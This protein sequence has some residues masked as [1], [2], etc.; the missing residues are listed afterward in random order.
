MGGGVRL[1]VCGGFSVSVGTII[2]PVHVF[3]ASSCSDRVCIRRLQAIVWVLL[4]RRG[5]AFLPEEK[6]IR[7]RDDGDCCC[8]HI[9]HF[10]DRAHCNGGYISPYFFLLY[11]CE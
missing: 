2:L 7:I 8:R 3:P 4:N 1:F 11:C 6:T 5:I 9:N 10:Y